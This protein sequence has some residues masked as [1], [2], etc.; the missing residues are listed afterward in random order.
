MERV[1]RFLRLVGVAIDDI[2]YKEEITSILQLDASKNSGR[3]GDEQ[4]HCVIS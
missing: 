1:F 2:R 4:I 3:I